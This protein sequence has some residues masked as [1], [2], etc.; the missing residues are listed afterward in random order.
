MAFNSV[1]ADAM[2]LWQPEKFINKVIKGLQK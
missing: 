1:A 2:T